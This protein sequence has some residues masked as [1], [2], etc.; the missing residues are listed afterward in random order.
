MTDSSP[1]RVQIFGSEYPIT[2]EAN[3]EHTR[4]VAQYVDRK[5]REIAHQMSLR[6]VAQIAVLTAVNLADELF[7]EME[8]GQKMHQTVVEKAD[9]L[10]DSLNRIAVE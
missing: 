1:I 4:K 5:M 2:T 6:S 7:K 8:E 3:A 10:G 9:L